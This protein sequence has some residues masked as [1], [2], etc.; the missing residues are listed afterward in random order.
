MDNSHLVAW[1]A[2]TSYN[3]EPQPK[4]GSR[5]SHPVKGLSADSMGPAWS[6]SKVGTQVVLEPG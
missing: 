6:T 5:V 1:S 4:D 3:I 2:T